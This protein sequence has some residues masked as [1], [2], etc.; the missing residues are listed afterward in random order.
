MK[1]EHIMGE[2]RLLAIDKAQSIERK[3]PETQCP[4]CGKMVKALTEIELG[5][6][7]CYECCM[8]INQKRG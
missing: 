7:T 8:E 4:F 1:V 2:Q 6:S 3:T 5:K